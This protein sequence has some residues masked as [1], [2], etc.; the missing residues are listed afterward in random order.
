VTV[1]KIGAPTRA[2]H[3]TFN[4]VFALLN[5]VDSRINA[6]DEPISDDAYEAIVELGDVLSA[7]VGQ[8]M[9]LFAEN[10]ALAATIPV[11]EAPTTPPPDVSDLDLDD[12]DNST[13]DAIVN[14][15]ARAPAPE[16]TPE[17][18]TE[19]PPATPVVLDDVVIAA[20][21]VAIALDPAQAEYTTIEVDLGPDALAGLTD[22]KA[23]D[24]AELDALRMTLRQAVNRW[25]A[26]LD[27]YRNGLIP[28]TALCGLPFIN[29]HRLRCDAAYMLNALN[30]D[31]RDQF[32]HDIRLTDSYR[33]ILDQVRLIV[34][35]PSLAASPGLSMHG[36]GLAIDLGGTVP[37]GSSAEYIWLRVNAPNY[38]WDNPPWA[39]PDGSK[40]EPW[41]FEFYAADPIPA[42]ALS[43]QEL[44]AYLAQLG[45]KIPVS[46]DDG[47]VVEADQCI[48]PPAQEN[49][50]PEAGPS[51]SPSPTPAP[52]TPS[53]SVTPTPSA[54][55]PSVSPSPST[56]VTPSVPPVASPTPSPSPSG[57]QESSW[58]SPSPSPSFVES[59]TT[60]E[61]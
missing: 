5:R 58:P 18:D 11:V 56:P 36:W 14:G 7:F 25:G 51:A 35:K 31:F 49:K 43:E 3:E 52:A 54:P 12:I 23:I 59:M 37:S 55:S 13:Y 28:D 17:P 6:S 44:A 29:G 60:D 45:L 30:K 15:Y 53:P 33:N 41:H 48:Q 8:N 47:A 2:L 38:G 39:R 9:A 32:G 46:C 20:M 16:E 27:G 19:E 57:S 10:E 26:S 1:G 50:T 22:G 34:A 42:R 21:K 24:P 40:P 61:G 4:Q